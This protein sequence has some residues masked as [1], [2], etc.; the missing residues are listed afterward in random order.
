MADIA[1]KSSGRTA[2]REAT[3]WDRLKTNNNWLSIWFMLPAAAFLI[4]FL[5]Y[6]LGLGVWLSFTDAKIGRGGEFIGI[7]NYEWLW[8]DSI[9]WLSVFNTL[10]YTIVAS[11]IKFAV[12]LYLALLLNENLPF[13]AIL[14]AVVLIPFIVPTVLVGNRVLVDLRQ[15]VLD[16]VMDVAPPRP[17]F[18]QYRFP[19]RRLERALVGDFR[20]YLARRAVCCHHAAC[21]FADGV[22]IAL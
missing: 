15:P 16:R 4:L 19:R 14:R 12:G 11:A 13:K 18:V 2:P 6:P 22:A 17:D 9:F 8:D 10:L 3:A 1:L 21:R 5:A 7:E 20:Q